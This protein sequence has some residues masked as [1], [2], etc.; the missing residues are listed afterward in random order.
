MMRLI[1]C[2]LTDQQLPHTELTESEYADLYKVAG[3]HQLCALV[4]YSLRR[5]KLLIWDSFAQVRPDE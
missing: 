5:L 3:D 4:A 1:T 2:A